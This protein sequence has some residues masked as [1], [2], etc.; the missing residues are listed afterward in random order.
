MQKSS[1]S[2]IHV[3]QF[4]NVIAHLK[5]HKTSEVMPISKWAK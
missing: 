4:K 2:E 3:I 1:W 5:L